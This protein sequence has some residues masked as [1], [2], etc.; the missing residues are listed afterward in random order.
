VVSVRNAFKRGGVS[1][2]NVQD[3]LLQL[4]VSMKQYAKL[5]QSEAARLCQASSINE[6]FFI[7]SPHCD[8]LNPS[9][10]AHLAYRFGDEQTIRLVEEYL[11]EL[12]EFRK[13]TK[14]GDFIDKWTGTCL[15][16]TQELVIEFG[17]N[18]REK[19]VEQLEEFRIKV[20]RKCYLED[21]MLPL[22]R[23]KSSS[24]DAVFSLPESVDIDSLELESLRKFFQEHHVLRILLNGVCILNVQ[25]QQVYFCLL[26][27]IATFVY[28]N[29]TNHMESVIATWHSCTT[30]NLV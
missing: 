8:F 11:G 3:S 12:T 21:Y 10:L 1:F 15:L 6:L 9:L 2:E 23:I 4:P 18:W 19:S 16:D 29:A 13:R 5:L 24:V 17:D 14:I 7:L 28:K 26:M 22:K 27:C 20:L 30:Q 25:L